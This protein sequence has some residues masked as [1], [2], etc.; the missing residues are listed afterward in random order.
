MMVVALSGSDLVDAWWRDSKVL[1][2][3]VVISMGLGLCSGM[4]CM[5]SSRLSGGSFLHSLSSAKPKAG[6]ASPYM[7]RAPDLAT[8]NPNSHMTMLIEST[9]GSESPGFRITFS[10]LPQLNVAIFSSSAR[11]RQGSR[12]IVTERAPMSFIR[13]SYHQ[14]WSQGYFGPGRMHAL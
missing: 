11:H 12:Q 3:R 4:R 8:A 13:S 1:Q 5:A 2:S 14:I 6:R 9:L 7:T 10:Y